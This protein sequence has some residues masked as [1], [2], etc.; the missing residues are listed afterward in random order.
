MS[1]P[2][3][4]VV[5]TVAITT[6]GALAMAVLVLVRQVQGL[7]ATL[8]TVQDDL[9]PALSSLRQDVEVTQREL[10]RVSDAAD[11]LQQARADVEGSG[12]GDHPRG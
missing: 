8:R 1:T 7:L 5:V 9:E 2:A 11:R 6:L 4:I 12:P 10:E 3:A